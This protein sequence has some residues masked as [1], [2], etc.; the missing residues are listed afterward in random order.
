[1]PMSPQKC[2]QP[3]I[4][5]SPTNTVSFCVMKKAPVVSIIIPAYN[6]EKYIGRCI[7]SVLNQKYPESDYEIVVVN[8][9]STDKTPYA[10]RLF[11]EEIRVVNN[12]E[13][14]G[15][16]GA[17]NAGIRAARG[18][19]VVRLDADDYVHAEYINVLNMY[20]SMN[21]HMDAVACDYHLVDDNE[22]VLE[23]KNC[24]E[25]PI[26]CGIMFRI[27]HLIDLGL[28]D[29]AMEMHEDK[30]LMIRF[31]EKYTLYRISLP[32]YRYRKHGHNMT[33]NEDRFLEYYDALKDKH[34]RDTVVHY[35]ANKQ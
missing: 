9:G 19:F 24:L 6:Q 35:T 10:L 30:D 5:Y 32:L 22:R 27:E 33:N 11:E 1:M 31:L 3:S 15:L 29:E 34:G 7:R 12:G 20:L 4:L 28:Y 17:L 21:E 23:T 26:G 16:P 25:E 14:L 13:N 2:G 8:D 18:R